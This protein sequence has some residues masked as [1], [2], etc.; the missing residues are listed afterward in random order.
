M[1]GGKGPLRVT[2]AT[3]CR[4]NNATVINEVFIEPNGGPLA[5][6]LR[7]CGLEVV[8]GKVKEETELKNDAMWFDGRGIRERKRGMTCG[9]VVV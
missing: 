3:P 9:C 2:K 8:V 4:I 5:N 7:V 6:F 1:A